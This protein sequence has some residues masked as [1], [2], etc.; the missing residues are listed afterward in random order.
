M[1]MT[2]PT[3]DTTGSHPTLLPRR[4]LLAAAGGAALAGALAACGSNNGRGGGSSG[5][6][7]ALSQWYHQYGEPG[8]EQAVERYAAAYRQARVTVQW[9]P[10]DYDT[11]TAAALLTAD[12]PDVFEVNG[13][14]LDQ[15]QGGQVVDLTDG[16]KDVEHDFNPAVL[17]PKTYRGRVYGI[18]QTIDT[19]LLY[20]RKSLLAKAKVSPPQT[21]DELV[22]AAAKL[23]TKDVKGLFLGNDG[24]AGVLGGTPLYA[25]GLQ[26][27]TPDGAVG[28]DSP[29]AYAALGKL[30]TLY[31]D[32]SLLLGAPAD[33]SDPSAFTQGL[34]AMQWSGL[35]ALPQISKALG[36]D[37]GVL[38][39]PAD[40][41]H[42]TP[43]VPVGAYA[44]AVS[45]R[46]KHV[47]A[48]KDFATW[49]WVERTDYQEDFAT[50][51]GLHIPAR[52]SLAERAAKLRDGAAA[53]AV[54]F[55][56]RYGHADPLLWTP[57]S[58]TALQDAYSRIIKDGADPAGQV[59]AAAGVVAA[60]LARVRKNG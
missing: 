35:W 55:A 56:T 37:F 7:P 8:T 16:I 20:Y 21:L 42:G 9:R 5:S 53:D 44:S 28:F 2:E 4:R 40:G 29:A 47:A 22:A 32:K 38:P 11:Q 33:W 36:D 10:G 6:G 30:H 13:P 24:G 19:Q 12:G 48:A 27:V 15:I 18:P 52:I 60:E 41:A 14:T 25:A 51:Y 45:A 43:A 59:K 31:A 17:G 26:L 34:T 46:S 49:L 23:T 39:F 3:R 50:S 1:T 57:K 58:R 54:R